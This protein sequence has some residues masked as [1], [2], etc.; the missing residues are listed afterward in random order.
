MDLAEE[1]SYPPGHPN[2]HHGPLDS[3]GIMKSAATKGI[4]TLF[5]LIIMRFA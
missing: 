5:E 4:L 2:F 3:G 1:F